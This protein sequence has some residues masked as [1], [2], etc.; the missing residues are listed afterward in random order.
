MKENIASPVFQYSTAN[1]YI[2]TTGTGAQSVALAPVGPI[3]NGWQKMEGSITIPA[4]ATA[5][6]VRL[7]TGVNTTYFDDLRV[8]PD[9]ASMKT[10]AYDPTSQRLLAEMDENNYATFYEY[11]AEGNLIRVKKETYNGIMTLKETRQ[12]LKK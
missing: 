2:E 5:F 12:N 3:I 4:N 10:F 7:A 1:I 9:K 8:H 11:D 6:K